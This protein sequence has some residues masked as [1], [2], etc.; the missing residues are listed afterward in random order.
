[1]SERNDTETPAWQPFGRPRRGETPP[2]KLAADLR[3]AAGDV[4]AALDGGRPA[5]A[6]EAAGRAV[7]AAAALHAAL[8]ERDR[9]ASPAELVRRSLFQPPKEGR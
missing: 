8:T 9:D 6:V 1:M 5:D 2:E 3:T 4:V 7:E